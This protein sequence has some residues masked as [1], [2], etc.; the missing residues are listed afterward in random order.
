GFGALHHL[1]NPG[2]VL[3]WYAFAGVVVLLPASY[4][5]RPVVL[6]AG[7]G[8]VVAALLRN[9]PWLLIA[10]LFP[11]GMALIRYGPPPRLLPPV[12]AVSAVAGAAATGWWIYLTDD[13]DRFAGHPLLVDVY[14]TAGVITA[15][16]YATG[17]LMV[18]RASPAISALLAPL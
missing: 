14:A 18:V 7:I 3:L 9:D 10:G 15:V 13:P 16:A 8:I 4:L 1:I 5:P 17:L 6:L 11:L 12:F 2:E